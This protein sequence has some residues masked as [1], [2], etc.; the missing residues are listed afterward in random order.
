[1]CVNLG[2]SLIVGVVGGCVL[3]DVKSFVVVGGLE[4][5]RGEFIDDCVFVCII[6]GMLFWV[7]IWLGFDLGVWSLWDN[8]LF[9]LVWN[10]VV[11]IVYM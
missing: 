8:C 11:W 6:K 10:M 7:W 9:V 2:S 4:I 5:I 3:V 1:M